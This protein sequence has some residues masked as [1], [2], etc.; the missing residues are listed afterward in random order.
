LGSIEADQAPPGAEE[1]L[2]T[3]KDVPVLGP[4]LSHLLIQ[5]RSF[6]EVTSCFGEHRL[7]GDPSML[8]PCRPCR[9]MVDELLG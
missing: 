8:V 4:P 7:G 2:P 3:L 6:M 1:P 5:P 9:R